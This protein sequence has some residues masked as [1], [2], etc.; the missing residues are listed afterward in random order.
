M[1]WRGRRCAGRVNLKHADLG[2]MRVA[3][4]KQ[5]LAD[6][7]ATCRECVEKADFVRRLES[8]VKSEL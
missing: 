1:C 3:Q 2:K 6:R 7:G 4:L 5:L 8:L